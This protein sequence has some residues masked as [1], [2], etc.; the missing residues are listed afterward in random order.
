MGRGRPQKR[1]DQETVK[2]FN[3]CN[4]V[5]SPDDISL[6]SKGLTFAPTSQPNPFVLFKDLN[7]FIHD[8]T[9]KRF[10]SIKSAKD[11][12]TTDETINLKP[13]QYPLL[14]DF[15]DQ[16]IL[17]H[18]KELFAKSHYDDID[19]LTQHCPTFPPI[20]HTQLYPK[21]AFNPIHKKGPYLQTFYKVVYADLICLCQPS[22]SSR[23][24]A[25]KL[26]SSKQKSLDDLAHNHDIV[27]NKTV[28][29]GGG[30][31]VQNKKYYIQ[32]DYYQ[33]PIHIKNY[34]KTPTRIFCRGRPSHR[35]GLGGTYNFS[36]RACFPLERHLQGSLLVPHVPIH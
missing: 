16:P 4:Y 29:N 11:K 14:D 21:S 6:L 2:I 24:V 31:V 32:E 22:H 28:D 27:K 12:S 34:F 15:S 19:W 23:L 20:Q 8:L 9:V 26:T 7:T 36:S 35:E 33:T 5:I 1:K 17:S 30:I 18:F 10:Y 25:I 3:L 13:I